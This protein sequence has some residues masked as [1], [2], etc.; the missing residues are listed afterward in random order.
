VYDYFPGAVTLEQ[1]YLQNGSGYLTED[2]VWSIATQILSA[3]QTIHSMGIPCRM[4]LPSKIILTGK[5][6]VR[7]VG[8]GILDIVQPES[9]R[10]VAQKQELQRQDLMDLGYLILSL[11]CKLSVV[12]DFP[13]ALELFAQRFSPDLVLLTRNLCTGEIN[14]VSQFYDYPEFTAHVLQD[15][16]Y[17]H[18]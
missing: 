13:G 9:I 15:S 11:T 6:R 18:E 5:N 3:L 17:M 10:T 12:D 7:I 4:I 1:E 16:I 2:M 14:S 8:G